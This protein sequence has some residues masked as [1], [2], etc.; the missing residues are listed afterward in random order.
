M[1]TPSDTSRRSAVSNAL[2][3]VRKEMRFPKKVLVGPWEDYLFFEPCMMFDPC[4]IE[5]KSSLLIEEKASIIALIKLGNV[6]PIDYEDPPTLFIDQNTEAKQYISELESKGAPFSW[7]VL[8]D[9]YVCASDKGNWSIYCEKENDVA[10]FAFCEGLSQSIRS[11]V[12]RLLRAKSIRF[13]SAIGDN[14]LFD[15]GKLTPDWLVTLAAEH[16][17]STFGRNG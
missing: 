5:V 10:V 17:P 9:R 15:F 12:G 14:Q 4:F 8:V 3:S 1:N 13:S 2:S 11:Q 16:A 7:R 6:I